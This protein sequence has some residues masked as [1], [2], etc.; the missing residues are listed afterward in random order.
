MEKGRIGKLLVKVF[1]ARNLQSDACV[2]IKYD[3]VVSKSNICRR[4]EDEDV[5]V[6]DEEFTLEV[7]KPFEQIQISLHDFEM[8]VC[9]GASHNLG[10]IHVPI[11]ELGDRK[12]RTQEFTMNGVGAV[13]LT[14]SLQLEPEPVWEAA[15]LGAHAFLHD[16]IA[17]A[18][19]LLEQAL[20]TSELAAY[21][22]DLLLLRSNLFLWKKDYPQALSYSQRAIDEKPDHDEGYFRQG[23]IYMDYGDMGQA[24][25]N[26]D[27]GLLI[28]RNHQEMALYLSYIDYQNEE[29]EIKTTLESAVSYFVQNKL[30]EA[31]SL[32][33]EARS[34]NPKEPIYCFYRSAV[35]IGAKNWNEAVKDVMEACQLDSTFVKSD[36]I[37]VG[38]MQK[39]GEIN[40]SYK[41]RWFVLKEHFYLFYFKSSVDQ[42]PQGVILI[43]RSAISNK[44]RDILIKTMLRDWKLK[45]NSEEEADEWVKVLTAS[46]KA[47]LRIPRNPT[48]ELQKKDF[49]INLEKSTCKMNPIIASVKERLLKK[50]VWR[51]I[52][53]EGPIRLMKFTKYNSWNK[54]YAVLQYPYLYMWLHKPT[55]EVKK[56]KSE[57]NKVVVKELHIACI[58]I[59]AGASITET[60]DAKL[61]FALEL[62]YH[63]FGDM[64]MTRVIQFE[65]DETRKLW[66]NALV[67]IPK[68]RDSM[69]ESDRT[70]SDDTLGSGEVKKKTLPK[71][72]TQIDLKFGRVDANSPSDTQ[73]RSASLN[74]YGEA[75]GLSDEHGH[76]VIE[77]GAMGGDGPHGMANG[78]RE[79]SASAHA[80]ARVASRPSSSSFATTS[81]GFDMS[82][83]SSR[84]SREDSPAKGGRNMTD[85]FF[86]QF[87]GNISNYSRGYDDDHENQLQEVFG[88]KERNSNQR[89]LEEQSSFAQPPT[90]HLKINNKPMPDTIPLLSMDFDPYT[91]EY[92]ESRLLSDDAA[93]K[94][95]CTCCEDEYVEVTVDENGNIVEDS[96]CV[97]F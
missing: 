8:K 5:V 43:Y 27:H 81:D 73:S 92:D 29:K 45:A 40:I 38:E 69:L 7:T 58:P 18:N 42:I 64:K 14:M 13:V 24:K 21:K 10:S 26:F 51:N 53:L 88:D 1:S 91:Q 79:S 52:V 86:K 48:R 78:S 66:L 70:D 3:Q 17:P 2:V 57:R 83:R 60:R 87:G 16:N 34:R 65:T 28:N 31:L 15:Y 90:C 97:L 96:A 93:A 55:T 59:E 36:S 62:V 68:P 6:W 49:N 25:K 89:H 63:T 84:S 30:P 22:F 82:N 4:G 20:K 56:S 94:K 80:R 9:E 47:P 19:R 61:G 50:V 46:S 67:N 32:V 71:S 12:Q 39:K 72:M 76:H 54:R 23:L 74:S 44:G 11:I 75:S 41:K 95:W 77:M 35:H 37:K 85:R 33:D